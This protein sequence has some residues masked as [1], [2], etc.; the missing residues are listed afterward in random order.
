MYKG[1][2]RRIRC[3]KKSKFYITSCTFRFTLSFHW[4]MHTSLCEGC[5]SKTELA[6]YTENTLR[7]EPFTSV[8]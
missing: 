4:C 2:L 3:L 7:S 8:H 1:N 6:F 5:C